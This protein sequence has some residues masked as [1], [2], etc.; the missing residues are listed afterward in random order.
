M[1]RFGM[2]KLVRYGGAAGVVAVVA[3]VVAFAAATA[4]ATPSTKLYTTAFS[5]QFAAAGSTGKTY[6]LTL[7]NCG[8]L[9]GVLILG[10]SKASNQTLGS[11]NF[12]IP[13]PYQGHVAVVSVSAPT[14][15]WA[16]TPVGDTLQ[17]RSATSKDGLMPGLSITVQLTID[18]PS[19]V[20]PTFCST[21]DDWVWHSHVKQSNDFS[22]TGNDF[23]RATATPDA[24]L[25]D[26]KLAFADQ[27]NPPGQVVVNNTFSAAVTAEDVCGTTLP[28]AQGTSVSLSLHD[29]SGAG[30]NL[31][32]ASQA[33]SI[34]PD[35]T[36]TFT[37]LSIDAVG[38]L[39]TLT[40]STANYF[41]S[42]TSNPIDV[43]NVLCSPRDHSCSQP[44]S[45][46]LI[47]ASAQVP[48]NGHVGIGFTNSQNYV[49][50]FTCGT[51]TGGLL[52]GQLILIDPTAD[53]YTGSN[54]YAV[55]LLYDKA[56]SGTGPASAFSFCITDSIASTGFGWAPPLQGCTSAPAPCISSQKRTTNGALQVVLQLVPGDPYVGG[57]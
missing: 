50:G 21:G 49:A 38:S 26:A 40:A 3:I 51:G 10:C 13:S 23:S 30:G 4:G 35:G 47:T 17:F 37:G 7:T 15:G 48:T 53:A 36:V 20:S 28:S 14:S 9:N 32:G 8:F 52:D 43:V 11:A 1:K 31:N 6:T 33:M 55:T 42:G 54:S 19:T 56:V 27:I 12:A 29:P 57:K 46:G 25:T 24:T 22:G 45:D 34:G 39:Y 44:N 18:A 5:P 41:A 16:V 2:G